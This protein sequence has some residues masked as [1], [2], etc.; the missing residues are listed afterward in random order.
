MGQ[1]KVKQLQYNKGFADGQL[2]PVYIL[3]NIPYGV[4]AISHD[5]D[6]LVKDLFAAGN[7]FGYKV[8][9]ER[10]K[11]NDFSNDRREMIQEFTWDFD[12]KTYI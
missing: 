11:L 4:V 5:K 3:S 7:S 6:R 2:R 1:K 12:K 9:L 8:Y 10:A